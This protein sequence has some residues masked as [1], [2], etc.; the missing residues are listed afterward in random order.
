MNLNRDSIFITNPEVPRIHGAA[1]IRRIHR[2]RTLKEIPYLPVLLDAPIS[3][4]VWT[5]AVHCARFGVVLFK[6]PSKLQ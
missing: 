4:G 5:N 6:R 1:L 2:K 3:L